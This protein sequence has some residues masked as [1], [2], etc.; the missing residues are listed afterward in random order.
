MNQLLDLKLDLEHKDITY[1]EIQN[2]QEAQ[3]ITL[4][5]FRVEEETLRL[6]SCNLW[7]ESSEKNVAFFHKQFRD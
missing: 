4:H 7:L 1:S 3:L 6:K 2:E 5:S